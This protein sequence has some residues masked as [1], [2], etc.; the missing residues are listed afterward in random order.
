MS[1]AQGSVGGPTM[2]T[3]QQQPQQ[4]QLGEPIN[5]FVTFKIAPENLPEVFRRLVELRNNPPEGIVIN[6]IVPVAGRL[7]CVLDITAA[8]PDDH[9][10]FITE[11]L[12]KIKGITS[13]ESLVGNEYWLNYLQQ[14]ARGGAGG[15]TFG[16]SQFQPQQAQ[17]WQWRVPQTQQQQQQY[18]LSGSRALRYR[19]SLFR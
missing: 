13:C 11:D 14:G 7:D 12:S 1:Q 6:K 3:G 8:S 19:Q 18:G 9:F 5:A 16:A 2:M 17:P 10:L 4:Q 15:Q